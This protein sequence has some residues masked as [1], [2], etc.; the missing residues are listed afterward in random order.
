MAY[1]EGVSR[2]GRFQSVAE[3][4]AFIVVCGIMVPAVTALLAAVM[5]SA[6]RDIGFWSAWRD[7]YAGHALG[8]VVFAPPLL[9][10]LRGD[11]A[12][13]TRTAGTR[14]RKRTFGLLGL[15]LLASLVTFGQS[16]IPLSSSRSCR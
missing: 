4:T 6:V 11:V 16:R 9:L 10:F 5:T 12:H 15:V 8:F 7:W 3:V 14:V 2:F 13:W 1:A